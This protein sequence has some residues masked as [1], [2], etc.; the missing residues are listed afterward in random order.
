MKKA[1]YASAAL[2]LLAGAAQAAPTQWTAAS[3]GNDHWYEVIWAR[4]N[5]TWEQ[6][7]A[8]AMAMSFNGQ[9]GYLASITSAG[10][11]SFLDGV[12]NAFATSSPSHGGTYVTAWIGGHDKNTEGSFE[13]TSGEAFSYTNW[14]SGEPNNYGGNEDYVQGWWSGNQWNDNGSGTTLQKY[15]VEYNSPSQV[16][17]PAS[18]PLAAAGFGIMGWI[19]RRRKKA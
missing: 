17:V 4:V 15:V 18:L 1:L 6:A 3:G 19:G 14:S 2:A 16:P 9:N 7:N 12:N 11:Q 10:E 8:A 13:W 5:L